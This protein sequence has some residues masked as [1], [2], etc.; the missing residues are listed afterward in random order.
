MTPAVK[1][2]LSGAAVSSLGGG[3]DEP[4][5]APARPQPDEQSGSQAASDSETESEPGQQRVAPGFRG[6]LESLEDEF[7]YRLD[8]DE[9]VG[10]IPSDLRGVFYRNGPGRLEVG[11]QRFGHWFDGDG[12]VCS[13]T[14][15]DHHDR[16]GG[17]RSTTTNVR[18]RNRY[19][20]TPKFEME[21]AANAIRCR[22]F[23]TQIPGG[24]KANIGR[25]PKS[26]A[27]TN[28]VFHGGHLLA[29]NEGGRPFELD[30]DSLE[31]LGEFTYRRRLGPLDFFSAHP[32][33]HQ[34]TGE[35][36]NFGMGMGLGRRVGLGP[37][38]RSAKRAGA[39][40]HL[41]RIRPDGVMDVKGF[42]PLDRLPFCHDF[43]ITDRHAVFFL[44]SVTYRDT[45]RFMSGQA[46]I[47]EC[48]EMQPDLAMQIAVVSLNTM[49]QTHLF[50]TEP[51]AI[52]HFGNAFVD[53]QA[54]VVDAMAISDPNVFEAMDADFGDAGATGSEYRR[55]RIDLTSGS[56][57]FE[58]LSDLESDFPTF[59]TS[60]AGRRSDVSFTSGFVDNG[61]DR[62]FNTIERVDPQRGNQRVTLPAG[63]Y[64]SEPFFAPSSNAS[65]RSSRRRNRGYVLHSVYNSTTHR[66]ELH[67]HRAENLDDQLAKITLRHHIP[68]QFHGSFRPL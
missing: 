37:D 53:R 47:A 40:L 49:Q 63:S 29:L 16:T 1:S 30:P 67:I 33:R 58:V 13:F 20:R 27:N 68:H 44:G 32:K 18:F 8:P 39:G 34:A 42:L 66:S 19:V 22:G 26:P 2:I 17:S 38:G 62:F 14:F 7:D 46:S 28:T 6:G 61:G 10:E 65:E 21:S 11:G 48:L 56:V 55:Y 50:E 31:T 51:G 5:S 43:V 35:L 64:G 3:A 54:I 52:S 60:Q 25:M 9:I 24:W 4:R 23:G 41:Y 12:M 45:H 59:D 57:T 15:D 36:I